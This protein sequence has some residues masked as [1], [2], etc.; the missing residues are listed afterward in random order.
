MLKTNDNTGGIIKPICLG[1]INAAAFVP[2]CIVAVPTLLFINAIEK[3][4][5]KNT[6]PQLAA[7]AHSPHNPLLLPEINVIILS[8]LPLLERGKVMTVCKAWNFTWNNVKRTALTQPYYFVMEEANKKYDFITRRINTNYFARI[9]PPVLREALKIG[10]IF[11]GTYLLCDKIARVYN[12]A[13]DEINSYSP[14]ELLNQLTAFNATP[15]CID[16][17]N[18]PTFCRTRL[19]SEMLTIPEFVQ[20]LLASANGS[21]IFGIGAVIILGATCAK[22]HVE[23]LIEILRNRNL[24]F[25]HKAVLEEIKSKFT[26]IKNLGLFPHMDA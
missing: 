9:I 25:H 14:E 19:P 7:N 26:L 2:F 15:F 23:K 22:P 18:A 11:G 1:I 16:S 20:F 21:K 5:S 12:C 8:H 17:D 4:S 24:N 13:I 10:L 6:P 3:F